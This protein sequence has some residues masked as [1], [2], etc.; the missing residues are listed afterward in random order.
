MARRGKP[1]LQDAALRDPLRSSGGLHEAGRMRRGIAEFL[2]LP[3]LITAGFTVAAVLVGVLDGA[4]EGAPLRDVA[5]AVVPGAG[6]TDFISAVATSLMTV[7]SITFS[8]LLLAVQQTASSLTPVVFDQYLRRR[9]NQAYFGFFVGVTAFAFIVLG[10][11]RRPSPGLRCGDLSLADRRRAGRAA[12]AH[13]LD[14]RPDAPPVGGA[15]D[16]RAGAA[17]A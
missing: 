6:A 2:R 17:G 13:P 1:T 12:A 5:T 15:V 3:L 7:T 16:P 11:A 4:G 10:L 14:R 8:V 9:S